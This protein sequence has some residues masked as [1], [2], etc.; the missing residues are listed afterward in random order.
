MPVLE[1]KMPALHL[2]EHGNL[3]TMGEQWSMLRMEY[4]PQ[5]FR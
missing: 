3:G 4:Y 2:R 5:A 1:I